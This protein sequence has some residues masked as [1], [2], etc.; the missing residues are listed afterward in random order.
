[1]NNEVK[2]DL[3]VLFGNASVMTSLTIGVF[4]LIAVITGL[5]MHSV[6]NAMFAILFIIVFYAISGQGRKEPRRILHSESLSC[7]FIVSLYA[8]LSGSVA[9]DRLLGLN[10]YN[11]PEIL[12]ISIIAF[13]LLIVIYLSINI[14]DD[15]SKP[16]TIAVLMSE[17]VL[18]F[19]SVILILTGIISPW[20]FLISVVVI[21]LVTY[22]IYRLSQEFCNAWCGDDEDEYG[23]DAHGAT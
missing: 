4:S 15:L 23:E 11:M 10:F 16:G 18:V 12:T 7:S 19:F 21:S 20:V 13:S 2:E 3:D 22:G 17:F 1:M 5:H 9:A 8:L 6:F 14:R